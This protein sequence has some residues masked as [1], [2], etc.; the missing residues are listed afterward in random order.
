MYH[1]KGVVVIGAHSI[2]FAIQ[3]RHRISERSY[4]LQAGEMGVIGG[5]ISYSVG[6]K[7]TPKYQDSSSSLQAREPLIGQVHFQAIATRTWIYTPCRKSQSQTAALAHAI[8]VGLPSLSEPSHSLLSRV[9][10]IDTSATYRC[11]T[12]QST[13]RQRPPARFFNVRAVQ[14]SPVQTNS[15]S[16]S[17]R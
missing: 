12:V 11:V 5:S 3:M 13:L 14:S 9:H 7:I 8:P 4:H 6:M 15:N 1:R 17:H 16:T 10:V 2:T